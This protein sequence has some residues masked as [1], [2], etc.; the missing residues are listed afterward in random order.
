[1][2]IFRFLGNH[3]Y[4]SSCLAPNFDIGNIQVRNYD[5]GIFQVI[6]IRG[7]HWGGRCS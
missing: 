2:I 3:R 6:G 5:F 4:I 7:R 1:M